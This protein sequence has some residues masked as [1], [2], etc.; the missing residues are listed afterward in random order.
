MDLYKMSELAFKN[1]YKKAAEEIFSEIE[2]IAKTVGYPETLVNGII[3]N[4]VLDGVYLERED[5]DN[6]K[7][8]HT[9]GKP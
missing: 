8:K 9:E 1:G 5:F 4:H 6:L 3:T 2:D 7:K